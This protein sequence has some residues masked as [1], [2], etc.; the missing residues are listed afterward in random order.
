MKAITLFSSG[1]IGDIAIKK[2]GIDILV[3]NEII[4]SRVKL[5]RYNFPNTEMI[6]GDI[7][8]KSED[9]IRATNK[10]LNG[11]ELDFLFAT[12]P[13]QGMS[14]NG[15]GKLLKG[16]RDG[17]KPKFDERNRLIIP[18]LKIIKALNPRT[19]V[20][21]NVPEMINTCI[22]DEDGNIINIIE[23]IEKELG[24][25]YVGKPEVVQFADFGVPQRRS[26]LITIYSRGEN[27]KKYYESFNTL[28]PRKTH[29]KTPKRKQKKWKTVRDTIAAFPKLDGK[30]KEL[31]CSEIPYHRVPVLDPKKYIWISNT[32][33]EK[34]AFDNQCINPK[35]KHSDNPI[36][37]ASKDK[38]GINRANGHTPL[39]CEKCGE[40]LPR[41]FTI[42]NDGKKRIMSGYTSAYKRMSWDL[43]SPTL[44]TN[45]C[46]PSSDHK[47]HPNQNRVLSLYE[48]FALHTLNEFNYKWLFS[49]S[50][51]APDTV[52]REVIGESIPP[53]GIYVI[54]KNLMGIIEG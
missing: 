9:I 51:K 6:H 1:G 17:K 45:L 24:D 35:C 23:Y 37:G 10:K 44:T 32:P 54:I 13:C 29:N 12:P 25:T 52:I 4:E 20:F 40:L 3:A 14:K 27:I 39:Y 30:N 47:I 8:D 7:W 2:L 19:V 31:A 28:I 34:G 16:I 53:K 26:R 22:E 36:H 42:K 33:P 5:H 38:H 18:T 21:E 15:Q 49:N 46:Y 43:P 50:E 48:A 41:P 11:S